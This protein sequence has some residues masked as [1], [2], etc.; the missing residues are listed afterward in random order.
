M[1]T[2]LKAQTKRL[3]NMFNMLTLSKIGDPIF[4]PIV[5]EI[6]EEKAKEPYVKMQ[7]KSSHSYKRFRCSRCFEIIR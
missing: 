1:T 2:I 7:W 6:V 4:N 5:I 3:K